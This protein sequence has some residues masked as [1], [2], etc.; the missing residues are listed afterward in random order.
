MFLS[1][2]LA[3][4]QPFIL[5]YLF[6]AIVGIGTG[7]VVVMMFA[8]FPDIPDVDELRSGERREGVYSALITFVRKLSSAVALFAVGISIDWA[9]Y[10]Q[11]VEEMVDGAQTLIEQPQ[12]DLF[13]VVLRVIFVVVPVVLV[14]IS[15]FFAR[16]YPLT[17]ELHQ[18][19]N[20]VL[21]QRRAGEVSAELEAE[22]A[23]LE[24]L[25]I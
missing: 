15:L 22:S 5:I 14:A 6:V 10:V 19:L 11:P 24:N 20:A 18:R 12:T 3:P 4:G 21:T 16:K 9:G 2:F 23:E 7:G 1:F 8:I 13:I 17:P 25:L